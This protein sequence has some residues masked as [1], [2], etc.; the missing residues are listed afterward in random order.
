M[1]TKQKIFAFVIAIISGLVLG[2]I[3]Y[4]VFDLDL[5]KPILLGSIFAVL[6]AH[7]VEPKIKE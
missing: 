2:G 1:F 7:K 4:Y 5:I 3:V 6:I